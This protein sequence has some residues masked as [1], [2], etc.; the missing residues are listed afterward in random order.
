[1]KKTKNWILGLVCK[2]LSAVCLFVVSMSV[3]TISLFGPYE[4]EMPSK[5]IPKD[6]E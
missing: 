2:T 4:H 1:M 3:K 6:G 5:L